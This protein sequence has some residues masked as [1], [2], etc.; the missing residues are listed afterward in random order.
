MKEQK[1]MKLYKVV[2][3]VIIVVFISV[4]LSMFATYRYFTGENIFTDIISS[5]ES[6]ED[7]IDDVLEEYRKVIDKY[8]IGE[9]EEQKLVEGAIDGYIDGIGDPYTDYIS[10]DEMEEYLESLSGNFVGV[11]IY[12]IEDVDTNM[13][14]I[15]SPIKNGPA[16]K[17]GILPGDIILSVDGE[18][19]TAD[20]M[21]TAPAKIKGEIGTTVK[22]EI[23][24]GTEQI[25]F[26]LVRDNIIINP[27]ESEML[28]SNIGY[29]SFTS[30][31]E[32]TA[33]SFKEKYLELESQ[34]AKSL[35][36]DL[37]N[38]GGGIVDQAL[39][40][41]DY[42]TDKDSVLLYE[43]DKDGKELI[44]KSKND[45]IINME[46]IILTNENTA[47]SSE[48]L[49][50]A[51]KD[52]GKAKTLGTTTFG[53]GVIQ[54]ILTMPDGS[55]LKVTSAKYLTPNRN[56]INEIGISPDIEVKL[57]AE[58]ENQLVIEKQED[59]QLQKAIEELK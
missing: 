21:D 47:S 36:V 10:P 4:G 14:Q 26:D 13:I 23:L 54:Q 55:G 51:L 46:V 41:A 32:N 33:E 37:R 50:G 22:L 11:G 31:D 3:T 7:E 8:Y 56:E 42:F 34:G 28:E 40:I 16:E 49:A 1:T 9:I 44:E 20:D 48:I 15:L 19:I 35:I 18:E 6:T 38:N 17:A 39:Q 43:V 12:M 52:L 2:I 45:P 25:E 5:E 29:I 59:L 27:V 58:L 24:R 53:K 30:F 57:P